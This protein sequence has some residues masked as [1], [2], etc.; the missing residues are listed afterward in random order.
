MPRDSA[1]GSS[2]LSA[3]ETILNRR[4]RLRLVSGRSCL[5]PGEV[6]SLWLAHPLASVLDPR[7]GHPRGSVRLAGA[8][9]VTVL[10]PSP[11]SAYS[12]FL[13]CSYIFLRRLPITPCTPFS[14]FPEF[15]PLGT[16]PVRLLNQIFP[17][18]S[19]C[20]CLVSVLGSHA[21]PNS[22]VEVPAPHVSECDLAWR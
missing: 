15:A 10:R 13:H 4:Q 9:T 22:Y 3:P 11:L 14:I 12:C 19:C 21:F 5:L 16:R 17:V 6:H 1:T 8:F 7:K 18:D 2:R 20:V